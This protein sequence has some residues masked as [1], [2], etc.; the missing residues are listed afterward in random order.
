MTR[1]HSFAPIARR[2]ARILILGSVPGVKSLGALEYYAHP[3]NAFWEIMD[4]LCG[5]ARGLPYEQRLERLQDAGI[6]V[7]DVLHSAE[8]EGSLDSAIQHAIPNDLKGL[9]EACPSVELIALNGSYAATTFKRYARATFDPRAGLRVVTLP[10]TSP[11]NARVGVQRK[12]ELWRDALE[13][14]LLKPVL[15]EPMLLASA[16]IRDA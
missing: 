6:A 5:A 16:P 4:A 10:S 13:P 12:I 8:R 15:L 11:A 9:L 14:D 7:W 2:D 1:I 3:R